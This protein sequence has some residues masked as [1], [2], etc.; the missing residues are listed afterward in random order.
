VSTPAMNIIMICI[1]CQ[2]QQLVYSSYTL[3]STPVYCLSGPF[4]VAYIDGA[5]S[6]STGDLYFDS[7]QIDSH[8]KS[9]DLRQAV[10]FIINGK[11]SINCTI[12]SPYCYDIAISGRLLNVTNK[13]ELKMLCEGFLDKFF[14]GEETAFYSES[15]YKMDIV[16]ITLTHTLTKQSVLV[17]VRDYYHV[18]HDDLLNDYEEEEDD[19]GLV[20]FLKSH[21]V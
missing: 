3:H 10:T 8:F 11:L 5:S 16:Q 13:A 15:F 19:D 20:N 12:Q 9:Y 14:Y 1:K 18:N 17:D 4:K 7:L 21:P 2:H 6:N